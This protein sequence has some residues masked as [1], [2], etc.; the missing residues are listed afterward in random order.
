MAAA[1]AEGKGASPAPPRP[2]GGVFPRTAHARPCP[3]PALGAVA[4]G[5]AWGC[6][7]AGGGSRR[8]SGRTRPCPGGQPAGDAGRGDPPAALGAGEAGF[9]RQGGGGGAGPPARGWGRQC[10]LVR[11]LSGRRAR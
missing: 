6:G 1:G 8:L 3:S 2:A 9:G 5:T 7:L 10:G 11:P 4:M